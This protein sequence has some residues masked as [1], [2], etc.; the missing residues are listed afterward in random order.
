MMRTR[1]R[2]LK[3]TGAAVTLAVTG[4]ALTAPPLIRPVQAQSLADAK[5]DGLVGER[6]D[7][8]VG[9]VRG[10]APTAIQAL[11]TRVNA[12]R[13]QNYD[14]IAQRTGANARDV[15]ILAGKKLIGTAA[16]GTHVMTPQGQW[17]RR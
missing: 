9:L 16:P 4:I 10:D 17:V 7:G 12:E 11:V 6:P 13:R 3:L 2:F 15:G 5:R 14:A 8:Y 1:R